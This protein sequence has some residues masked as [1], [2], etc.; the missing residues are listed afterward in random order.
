VVLLLARAVLGDEAALA[1]RIEYGEHAVE[2][3]AL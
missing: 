1:L 3:G 2:V